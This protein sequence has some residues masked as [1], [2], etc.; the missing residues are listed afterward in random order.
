MSETAVDRAGCQL[1]GESLE[2]LVT[3]LDLVEETAPGGGPALPLRGAFGPVDG[4]PVGAFRIYSG[5]GVR[6]VYS[7]LT[8][9]ALGL[10]THQLY[11]FTAAGSAVPHFFL[12]SAISPST[13]GT[14]HLGLDL[15]PRVDLGVH[16]DYSEAVYGGLA[17]LRGGA[18]ALPGVL[19]VP[20][21]GPVQWSLRSPWMV[22]AITDATALRSLGDVVAAYRDRWVELVRSGLPAAAGDLPAA[23]ALAERDARSRALLFSARTNPVWG[24]LG[25]LVGAEQSDAMRAML[26]G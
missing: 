12:D 6:L 19:P 2:I 10:D 20:S 23:A 24:L 16:L 22:A 5:S 4:Q 18:L 11:G 8:H 9:D 15:S 13:D 17:D 21:L 1:V 14:F 7:A 26:V 3:A 25:K